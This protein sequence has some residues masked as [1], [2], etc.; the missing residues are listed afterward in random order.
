MENGGN[1]P[2][3]PEVIGEVATGSTFSSTDATGLDVPAIAGRPAPTIEGPRHANVSTDDIMGYLKKQ[4]I[5]LQRFTWST[6]Q[7]PGT[8]LANIPISPLRANEIVAYLSGIFNAWNGGLEYQAKVA[9]TGFHAGALGIARIPPNIDPTTL[10][11]VSQF[12][13]FEYSVI[14][15]KTLEAVSKHIP[16][17]RPIMYHYMSNNFTD[18]NNIGG[19]FV[20]F[21]ILQLNTSS[22]GTNQIDV[23][24]FN[25]LAPDFRFIQVVPPNLASQPSPDVS[26][27]TALFSTPENHLHTIFP[28]PISTMTINSSSFTSAA[29]VGLRNLAG[30]LFLDDTYTEDIVGGIS[31]LGFPFYATSATSLIPVLNSPTQFN[32]SIT[33]TMTTPFFK[34][35]SSTTAN[36]VLAGTSPTLYNASNAVTGAIVG[37]YYNLLPNL[38]GN[39]TATYPG[40]PTSSAPVSESLITFSMG[41]SSSTPPM[42]TTRFL[43]FAFKTRNYLIAPNEAVLGQVF[44]KATGLPLAYVKIYYSGIITSNSQLTAINLDFNDLNFQFIQY[45]QASTPIPSLTGVML[46]SLQTIRLQALLDRTVQLRLGD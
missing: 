2:P 17:Q 30:E 13:A 36:A 4:H 37:A 20:I 12:T 43:S 19:H 15:P 22:T 1:N 21:V 5:S 31:N 29:K 38:S 45:I 46:Q 18:P 8:L 32:K 24:I 10:K 33:I 40:V 9:G 26:K 34:T 27:W 23:E 6:S 11:T 25:K 7:L 3:M 44:S 28:F 42:L 35:Y 41:G 39:I 16:D 14:D